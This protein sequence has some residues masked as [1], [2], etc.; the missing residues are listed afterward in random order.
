MYIIGIGGM[1]CVGLAIG[2]HP[3]QLQSRFL[4]TY[5]SLRSIISHYGALSLSLNLSLTPPSPSP[6]A[7]TSRAVYSSSA[8]IVGTSIYCVLVM[9]YRSVSALD[10]VCKAHVGRQTHVSWV[11]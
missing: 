8:Q 7:L 5:R 11:L 4:P 2:I 1:L 3:T 9:A 10:R 6:S